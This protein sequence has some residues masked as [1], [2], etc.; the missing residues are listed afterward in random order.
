MLVKRV[1]FVFYNKGFGLESVNLLKNTHKIFMRT[2]QCSVTVQ[3]TGFEHSNLGFHPTDFQV[4]RPE[5]ITFILLGCGFEAMI[6]V[7]NCVLYHSC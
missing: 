2:R 3:P 4:C 5:K 1:M 7:R 6:H